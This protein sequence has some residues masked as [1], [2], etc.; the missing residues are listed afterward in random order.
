MVVEY[1]KLKRIHPKH[2][3]GVLAL[4]RGQRR[5]AATTDSISRRPRQANRTDS[6]TEACDLRMPDLASRPGS[7]SA[8][9][10][11]RVRHPWPSRPSLTKGVATARPPSFAQQVDRDSSTPSSA[12]SS[13]SG[14]GAPGSPERRRCAPRSPGVGAA[15]RHRRFAAIA[16][17]PTTS[18]NRDPG[19]P[20]AV[21]PVVPASMRPTRPAVHR[22]C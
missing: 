18:S 21:R 6:T 20:H 13:G 22:G 15:R 7:L 14:C 4:I 19:R 5:A 8:I 10:S 3:G 11:R 9:R 2:V 1:L 12:A 16:T 17:N